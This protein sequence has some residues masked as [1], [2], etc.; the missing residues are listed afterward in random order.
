MWTNLHLGWAS[1][2]LRPATPPVDR[3]PT[4][5]TTGILA[6]GASGAVVAV[7]EL[8]IAHRHSSR[9]QALAALL[10][11]T[12]TGAVLGLATG[13]FRTP[14]VR[15]AALMVPWV[16]LRWRAISAAI[17]GALDMLVRGGAVWPLRALWAASMTVTAVAA[18]AGGRSAAQRAGLTRGWAGLCGLS[19]GVAAETTGVLLTLDLDAMTVAVTSVWVLLTASL[20]VAILRP[21]LVGSLA[22]AAVCLLA[23]SRLPE[24]YVELR[25]AIEGLL[26]GSAT[27]SMGL[28][29]GHV[30]ALGARWRLRARVVA[31]SGLFVAGWAGHALADGGARDARFGVPEG[32]GLLATH[33]ATQLA[34]VD[35]DGDQAAL[36]APDCDSFDASVHPSHHEVPGNGKDDNCIGG[37]APAGAAERVRSLEARNLPPPPTHADVV[38]VTVDSLRADDA[39]D[40]NMPGFARLY[41]EGIAFERAYSSSTF[42]SFALMGH[43]AARLPASVSFVFLSRMMAYSA[44]PPGGLAPRLHELGYDTA[45]VGGVEDRGAVNRFGRYF[46]P[47]TYGAGFRLTTHCTRDAPTKDVVDAAIAAWDELDRGGPRLLWVHE[48]GVHDART[49]RS[50]YLERV[51]EVGIE[52]DRLRTRLG[53]EAVVVVTA[54]HGEEFE[55]H[56]GRFHARTLFDEVTRVPLV[57]TL[58]SGAHGV[59]RAVSPL[60]SLM[61]TLVA[62]V[63]PEAIP[64]GRGPYLCLRQPA[65]GDLPVPMALELGGAHLHGLVSGR[66]KIT[67]DLGRGTLR[68]FDLAADAAEQKPLSPI[69]G[70]LEAEL[71]AWEEDAMGAEDSRFFWPYEPAPSELIPT[72]SAR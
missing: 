7:V 31:S 21:T 16:A 58:P 12:V 23:N 6:G 15:A 34:D 43:L 19:I 11:A 50:A 51:A 71:V 30:L 72:L 53:R 8:A 64:P 24:R 18:A 47:E 37:D 9:Y 42:T 67:R 40:P 48:M 38:L 63:A 54:D 28:A 22:I 46:S 69:P 60:R 66:R 25:Y 13:F 32:A 56:G 1:P 5:A 26:L 27:L 62:M 35:G 61:P 3:A 10:V 29:G 41:R 70:D 2:T 39:A 52:I 57:V 44:K 17:E 45:F 49:N 59:V 33:F 55:E 65:C 68:G 20:A 4:G 36:G 14:S